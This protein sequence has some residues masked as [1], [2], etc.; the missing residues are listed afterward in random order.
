MTNHHREQPLS[1]AKWLSFVEAHR[2]SRCIN[3]P[4]DDPVVKRAHAEWVA[5]DKVSATE[6]ETA[7]STSI[8][9]VLPFRRCGRAR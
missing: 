9:I 2:R 4:F 5:A 1:E 8:G 6:S 3:R 7:P